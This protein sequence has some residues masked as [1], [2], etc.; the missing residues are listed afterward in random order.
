MRS[1]LSLDLETVASS[2][3]GAGP[4]SRGHQRMMGPV[5]LL[6]GCQTFLMFVVLGS[7]QLEKHASHTGR[8]NAILNDFRLL[9]SRDL[10]PA[11]H[12]VGD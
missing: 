10:V 9:P 7:Q 4:E 12:T 3:P 11:R 6:S 2:R 5:L 8:E 1:E